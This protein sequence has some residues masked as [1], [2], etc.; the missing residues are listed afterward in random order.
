MDWASASIGLGGL[1]VAGLSVW[2]TH[3]ERSS[4]YR[5]R[6]YNLQLD[7]L[8]E[9]LPALDEWHRVS[10]SFILEQPRLRLNDETRPILRERTQEAMLDYYRHLRKWQV[11]LPATLG[12]ALGNFQ[13]TFNAIS[14]IPGFTKGYDPELVNTAD[15]GMALAVAFQ[16]VTRAARQIVGVEPLSQETLR[17]IGQPEA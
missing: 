2:L 8:H 15:P 13:G 4:P 14:A 11:F 1:L 9:I 12:E 5:H 7:G 16:N 6:L 10:Q 3:R 17:L